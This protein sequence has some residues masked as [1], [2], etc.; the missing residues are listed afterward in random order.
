MSLFIYVLKLQEGKYYIGR[1]TNPNIRIDQ[2]MDGRGSKWTTKYKP[3]EVEKI[4]PN[5]DYFDEDKI[6]KQY[7]QLYG[8]EN[9]RGASYTKMQL[10][11]NEIAI[12]NQELKNAA[13]LCFICGAKDHFAK[14]CDKKYF[15]ND[16][17]ITNNSNT[18]YQ[19]ITILYNSAITFCNNYFNRS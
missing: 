6:T 4:I 12:I 10:T 8:I 18:I 11:E 9:V 15:Q 2:H 3:I 19:Q 17:N 7:M 16:N 1:T 5:C 14:D 13:D